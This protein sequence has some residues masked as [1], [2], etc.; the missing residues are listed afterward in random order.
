MRPGHDVLKARIRALTKNAALL[1][2]VA[3]SE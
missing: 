3:L 1:E 2:L